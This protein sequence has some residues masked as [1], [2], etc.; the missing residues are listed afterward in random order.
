MIVG[1]GCDL[2]KINRLYKNQAKF[3]ARILHENELKQYHCFHNHRQLEFLAGRFAAK[4]AII[5]ALPTEKTSFKIIE[6][7]V[8]NKKLLYEDEQY[9]CLVTITHEKEY[10]QAYAVCIKKYD[11]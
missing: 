1:V 7:E 11:V 3:A 8:V 9:R 6:I 2:I 5:K 4:E 10:A